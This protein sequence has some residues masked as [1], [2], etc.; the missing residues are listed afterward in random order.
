MKTSIP[1]KFALYMYGKTPPPV[2]PVPPELRVSVGEDN[3]DTSW[4]LVRFSALCIA[5]AWSNGKVP[6]DVAV[7]VSVCSDAR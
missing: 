2:L 3:V 4:E 1:A 5:I 6:P 7:L